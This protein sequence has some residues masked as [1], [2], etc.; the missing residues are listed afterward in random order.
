[1]GNAADKINTAGESCMR[2]ANRCWDGQS[3]KDNETRK[4][5]EGM[6]VR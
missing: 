2:G 6:M 5:M 4:A 3:A 1:M